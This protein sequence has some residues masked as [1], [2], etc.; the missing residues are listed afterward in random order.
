[1]HFDVEG[2]E[3]KLKPIAHRFV[4]RRCSVQFIDSLSC[5]LFR[6]FITSAWGI[7]VSIV[8]NIRDVY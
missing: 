4:N 6:L 5:G 1:M 7:V 8:V 3:M 2:I